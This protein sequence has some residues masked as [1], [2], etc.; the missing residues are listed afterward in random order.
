MNHPEESQEFP[1]DSDGV[2]PPTLDELL[3]RDADSSLCGLNKEESNGKPMGN[4]LLEKEDTDVEDVVSVAYK[5]SGTPGERTAVG[6]DV[7]SS[8]GHPVAA[9][10]DVRAAE[11]DQLESVAVTIDTMSVNEKIVNGMREEATDLKTDSKLDAGKVRNLPAWAGLV[12]RTAACSLYCFVRP[13]FRR[14]L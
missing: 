2:R 14:A 5:Q 10:P 6:T 13:S 11:T 1:W 3:N 8:Q 9:S 4:E 7:V 12:V